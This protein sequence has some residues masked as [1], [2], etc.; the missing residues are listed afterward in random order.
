MP[1]GDINAW[2]AIMLHEEESTEIP[3]A[4]TLASLHPHAPLCDSYGAAPTV[5]RL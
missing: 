2:L 3:P 4:S 1:Q 5:T